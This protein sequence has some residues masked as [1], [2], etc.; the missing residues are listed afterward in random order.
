MGRLERP[1]QP[2]YGSGRKP[3]RS[4]PVRNI[5]GFLAHLRDAEHLAASPYAQMA[6]RRLRF[7]SSE[8]VDV[9]SAVKAVRNAA[10]NALDRLRDHDS[11]ARMHDVLMRCD[12]EG[13]SH[14]AVARDL[15]LSRRQLYRDLFQARLFV[16]RA[17]VGRCDPG[18]GRTPKSR[19]PLD[20]RLQIAENL[21]LSGQAGAACAL[22]A[23]LLGGLGVDDLV[24]VL[25]MIGEIAID[26]G[27][28]ERGCEA[29]A[30][31]R[32]AAANS[33]S[34][35]SKA[36]VSYVEAEIAC[37]TGDP[38]R[39]QSGLSEAAASLHGHSAKNMPGLVELLSRILNGQAN[40]AFDAGDIYAC[41]DF[42]RRNPARHGTSNVEESTY[43]GYLINAT[44]HK[45]NMSGPSAAL[46]SALAAFD[47]AV[48]HNIGT[49]AVIALVHLAHLEHM[50][51]RLHDALKYASEAVDY[52]RLLDGP[53]WR[54]RA[55]CEVAEIANDL[56][57]TTLCREFALEARSAASVGSYPWALA[58]LIL[59][60]VLAQNG[61]AKEALS[62]CDAVV[63]AVGA[64]IC[65]LDW[66]LARTR[67]TAFA[68]LD[69]QGDA[70]RAIDALLGM[71]RR[72]STM[73]SEFKTL[74][75]AQRLRPHQPRKRRIAEISDFLGCPARNLATQS[76][77]P[78]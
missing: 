53:A 15:G 33:D 60:E 47:F 1:D 28:S 48:G 57:E 49:L 18:L 8:A 66:R 12:V 78:A 30:A 20:R 68:A 61:G 27:S 59:A 23:P 58:Q 62:A 50:R 51:W 36:R 26:S 77:L 29:L 11:T 2:V 40:I 71:V 76:I 14:K 3:P 7:E 38:E 43:G 74:I 63:C 67:A 45:A 32:R 54:A 5:A 39:A 24:R 10:Y 65:E 4:A 31:A 21:A 34:A 69:R 19:S 22:L 72:R 56:H 16:E 35:V 37:V 6:L 17:I 70:I 64:S 75:I 73:L 9:A 46:P 13:E 52:S 55:C 25:C 44:L 42:L 41:E